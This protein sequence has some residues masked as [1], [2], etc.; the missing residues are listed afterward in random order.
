MNISEIVRGSRII[1]L[2]VTPRPVALPRTLRILVGDVFEMPPLDETPLEGVATGLPRD[3]VGIPLEAELRVIMCGLMIW[4]GEG[5]GVPAG[6]LLTPP[7]LTVLRLNKE[8][9][10]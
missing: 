10:K 7:E 4:F 6:D 8:T 1:Y 2:A 3:I 9:Y 5:F